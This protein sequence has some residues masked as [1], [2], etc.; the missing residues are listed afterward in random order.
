MAMKQLLIVAFVLGMVQLSYG[1]GADFDVADHD[2]DGKVTVAEFH[3]YAEQKLA[4]F[5]K[6]D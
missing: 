2:S 4:G 6:M 1:Q 5:E 3:E